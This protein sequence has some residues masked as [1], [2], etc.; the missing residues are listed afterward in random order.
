MNKGINHSLL[1]LLLSLP[2][3]LYTQNQEVV[4]TR[5]LNPWTIEAYSYK[6]TKDLQS[7]LSISDSLT[8]SIQMIFY[9]DMAAFFTKSSKLSREEQKKETKKQQEIT[10]NKIRDLLTKEQVKKFDRIKEFYINSDL[11]TKRIQN[12]I[13]QIDLESRQGK[14]TKLKKAVN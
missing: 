6:L 2:T 1:F 8:C 9:D 10:L 7:E 14:K 11:K 12:R 3:L 5:K 13:N 4:K